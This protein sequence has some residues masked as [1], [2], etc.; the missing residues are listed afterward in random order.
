MGIV[1]T[2]RT[3]VVVVV[4]VVVVVA[5]AAVLAKKAAPLTSLV[6]AVVVVVAV[7]ARHYMVMALSRRL[8]VLL[9]TGRI[10]STHN[11]CDVVKQYSR[12]HGNY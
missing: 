12:E 9:M 4:E 8:P 5:A 1:Q 7:P 6:M 2:R 3:V 10:L 11:G